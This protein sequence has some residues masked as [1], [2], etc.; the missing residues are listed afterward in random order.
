MNKTAACIP[1]ISF[2]LGFAWVGETLGLGLEVSLFRCLMSFLS[3]PFARMFYRIRIHKREVLFVPG[4][5]V[6][7]FLSFLQSSMRS[8]MISRSILS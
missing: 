5:P 2:V 6:T 1:L 7:A 3:M 8:I 4:I